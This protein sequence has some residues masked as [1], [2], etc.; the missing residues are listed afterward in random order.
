MMYSIGFAFSEQIH[1]CQRIQSCEKDCRI[2][3]TPLKLNRELD[4]L[5]A[6]LKSLIENDML[7]LTIYRMVKKAILERLSFSIKFYRG[8]KVIS[9]EL[10]I[11]ISI[12]YVQFRKSFLFYSY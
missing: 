8:F 12:I 7:I 10:G 9:M 2:G 5:G 6:S 3:I 11:S 4:I 1:W